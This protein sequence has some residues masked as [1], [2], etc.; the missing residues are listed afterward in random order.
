MK[1]LFQQL[2]S[3]FRRGIGHLLLFQFF[4]SSILVYLI[5]KLF[6]VIINVVEKILALPNIER[7]LSISLLKS[8]LVIPLLIWFISTVLIIFLQRFCLVHLT[9]MIHLHEKISYTKILREVFRKLFSIIILGALHLFIY[10][11]IFATALAALVLLKDGWSTSILP[12]LLPIVLFL[13]LFSFIYIKT[14]FSFH[15]LA[16]EHTSSTQAV[17]RSYILTK[18]QYWHSS[19]FYTAFYISLA[20][21]LGLVFA[22]YK[23]FSDFIDTIAVQVTLDSLSA[24]AHNVTDLFVSVVILVVIMIA[25]TTIQSIFKTIRYYKQHELGHTNQ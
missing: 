2:Y 4:Y 15:V 8:A 21:L 22:F 16:L 14:V 20:L 7:L 10:A 19:V 3:D 24:I 13:S 23:V 9:S 25:F 12:S 17:I 18:D 1:E 11:G 5:V 6:S